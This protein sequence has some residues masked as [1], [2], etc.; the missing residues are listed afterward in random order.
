V[1]RAR[2]RATVRN[3]FL[4]AIGAHVLLFAFAPR[5]SLRPYRL[6]VAPDPPTLV[7][8][9]D[10]VVP[11]PPAPLPGPSTSPEPFPEPVL[12]EPPAPPP[13]PVHDPPRAGGVPA[14]GR[15][16]RAESFFAYDAP[17]RLLHFEAPR[18]PSLAREAG[19]EGTVRLRVWIDETGRVT[20]AIVIASEVTPSMDEAA[21]EAARRCRFEPAK[22]RDVAVP[23]MVEIPF[24]FRLD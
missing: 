20:N 16:G 18:Y 19:I 7:E 24:V 21:L 10:I 4:A 15:G 14:P 8:V 13:P 23:A 3:A 1:L 17:P 5:V 11:A 9:D 2:Y 6:A 22:Q 12:K